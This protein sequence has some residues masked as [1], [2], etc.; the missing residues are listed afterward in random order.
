LRVRWIATVT[1]LLA[2]CCALVPDHLIGRGLTTVNTGIMITIAAMQMAVDALIG[3]VAVKATG[4]ASAEGYRAA[5]AF[6]A[7]MAAATFA[8][9]DD[10]KPR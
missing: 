9:T 10:H 4:Q 2:H 3:T 6:I 5:F 1:L 8:T 7:V